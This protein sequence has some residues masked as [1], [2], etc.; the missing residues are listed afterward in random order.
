VV[1]LRLNADAEP[2][3]CRLRCA[4]TKSDGSGG[5]RDSSGAAVIWIGHPGSAEGPANGLYGRLAPRLQPG[6]IT[7]LQLI[8]RHPNHLADTVA[9]VIAGLRYLTAEGY[10]R[11]ALVGHA[12]GA[13]AAIC[14]AAEAPDDTAGVAAVAAL[15]PQ[16]YGAR[17]KVAALAPRPLLLLHGTA[18]TILPAASSQELYALA[19]DPKYLLLYAGCRH[20]L[21]LCADAVDRDLFTWLQRALD[22][23]DVAYEPR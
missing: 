8:Y 11:I 21:A 6:G 15:S 2:V 7:S 22:V 10:S 19:G 18:D 3:H 5:R 23:A 1:H 14:A 20:D 4:G 17:E 16:P 12:F 9:D 13:A